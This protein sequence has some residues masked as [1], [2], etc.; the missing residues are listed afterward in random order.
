M[1]L[2][3]LEITC[4][5]DKCQH[6][7]VEVCPQ[8]KKNKIAI[9]IKKSIAEV[10]DSHC[11]SCFQCTSVCPKENTLTIGKKPTS[12]ENNKAI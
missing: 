1:S 3:V 6:E 2:H 10:I 11:I 8:N 12:K 9:K 7:C 5:P 4:S